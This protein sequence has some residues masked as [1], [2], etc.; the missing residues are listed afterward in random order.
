MIYFGLV[1][2]YSQL[3]IFALFGGYDDDFLCVVCGSATK[4]LAFLLLFIYLY[5]Y[6][7]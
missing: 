3:I 2:S 5:I 6:L 4:D 7:L 1:H